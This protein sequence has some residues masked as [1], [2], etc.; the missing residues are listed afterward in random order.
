M[1]KILGI[2]LMGCLLFSCGNNNAD[3]TKNG[4]Y[5]MLS[6]E[7]DNDTETPED[8]NFEGV[9][10]GEI[11]G[12]K[13]IL[14]IKGDTFS[15][16]ENGNKVSG[17]WQQVDDGTILGLQPKTGNLT[18]RNFAYSDQDTWVALTDSLTYI[19]PEQYLKREKK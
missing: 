6:G 11:N 18:V 13:V 16:T 1:N 15:M 10:K 14:E 3:R 17:S 2:I 8:I 9:Y 5:G 7:M 12:K 19:E 4:E